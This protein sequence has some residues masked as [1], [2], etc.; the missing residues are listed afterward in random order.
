VTA[1]PSLAVIA[2]LVA[3]GNRRAE[4]RGEAKVDLR[5]IYGDCK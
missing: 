5:F 3:C 1:A 2:C 4:E